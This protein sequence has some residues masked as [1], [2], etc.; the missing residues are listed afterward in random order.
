M[1]AWLLFL[2]PPVLTLFVLMSSGPEE[3]LP[4]R[5]PLHSIGVLAGTLLAALLGA[6]L[7]LLFLA[8]TEIFRGE[9]PAVESHWGGFGGGLGGW[10]ISSSLA[11]LL[12]ALFLGGLFGALTLTGLESE[13]ARKWLGVGPSEESEGAAPPSE[14]PVEEDR[15]EAGGA[16][17]SGAEGEEGQ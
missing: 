16:G 15:Q 11:Y 3:L 1:V 7:A 9:P 13:V 17:G 10:R 12:A 5:D 8:V 6:S 4:D 14:K 2:S